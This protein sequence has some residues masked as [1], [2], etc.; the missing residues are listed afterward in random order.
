[1]YS[2]TNVLGRLWLSN[3]RL[4]CL[5]RSQ[6]VR[7]SRKKEMKFRS[8]RVEPGKE[9]KAIERNRTERFRAIDY[10][11]LRRDATVRI[12]IRQTQ[13]WQ[14]ACCT[15]EEVN[16]VRISRLF[17]SKPCLC[18]TCTPER[19]RANTRT[20]THAHALLHNLLL[21]NNLATR[22]FANVCTYCMYVCVC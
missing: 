21:I 14:G 12:G 8:C 18:V 17:L 1:M 22:F 15:N 3:S 9:S 7:G 4:N 5:R 20:H 13:W 19:R 16:G 6:G 11:Y 2:A 10:K